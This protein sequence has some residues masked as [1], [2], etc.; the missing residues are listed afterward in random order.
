VPLTP[1]TTPHCPRFATARGQCD[2]C[3]RRAER[4]RTR[5]RRGTTATRD[6][7]VKARDLGERDWDRRH[8][9]GEG[10]Q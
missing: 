1:C 3:R 8:G 5:Q 2:I 9:Q 10:R 7:L 4:E 6:E